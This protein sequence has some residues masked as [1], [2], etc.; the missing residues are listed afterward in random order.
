MRHLDSDSENEIEVDNRLTAQLD[1]LASRL[2]TMRARENRLPELF[3]LLDDAV[4]R[5]LA[6]LRAARHGRR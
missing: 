2:P 4:Q 5:V 6:V 1:A 3:T